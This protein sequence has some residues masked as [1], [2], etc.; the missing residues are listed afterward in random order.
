[1]S[2][3]KPGIDW[4]V[5]QL[6]DRARGKG[7]V[8]PTEVLLECAAKELENHAVRPSPEYRMVPAELIR[9]LLNFDLVCAFDA[10][11]TYT[12]KKADHWGRLRR[13]LNAALAAAPPVKGESHE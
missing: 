5:K 2:E 11:G 3:L 4:L 10:K 13:R 12:K 8:P 7:D 6:R 9:D 1:M